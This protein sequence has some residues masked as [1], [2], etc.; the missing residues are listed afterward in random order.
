LHCL[1]YEKKDRMSQ[2][3]KN[4]SELAREKTN[5][6][7]KKLELNV[8]SPSKFSAG[9]DADSPG[10]GAKAAFKTQQWLEVEDGKR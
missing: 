4:A 9:R 1:Y 2:D 7:A 10:T 8:S 5:I 3:Q 6:S